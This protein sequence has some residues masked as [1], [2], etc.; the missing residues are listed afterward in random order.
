MTHMLNREV[1]GE[2]TKTTEE[3]GGKRY[4][5]TGYLRNAAT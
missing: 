5:S 2:K 4:I 3:G 1:A